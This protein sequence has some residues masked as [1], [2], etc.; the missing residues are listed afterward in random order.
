MKQRDFKIEKYRALSN[1]LKK[2]TLSPPTHLLRL[3]PL[4]CFH[5]KVKFAKWLRL[6]KRKTTK[7]FFLFLVW[8]KKI[9]RKWQ[10]KNAQCKHTALQQNRRIKNRE[11]KRWKLD[12]FRAFCNE[13]R[14]Q[15]KISQHNFK[16]LKRQENEM[17]RKKQFEKK[18]RN[19]FKIKDT[20]YKK[21][22]QQQQ[23]N[24]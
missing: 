3:R 21:Q 10:K 13:K 15:K 12:G 2:N 7:N 19:V 24:V 11:D 14:K 23:W 17:K 1:N 20:K 16:W 22:Q 18:D 4:Q 8:K 5:R 6:T 9:T